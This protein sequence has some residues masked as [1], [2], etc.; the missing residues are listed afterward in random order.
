MRSAWFSGCILLHSVA[1]HHDLRINKRAAG[2]R[3][4]VIDRVRFEPSEP[5]ALGLIRPHFAVSLSAVTKQQQVGSI[6][7]FHLSTTGRT[8]RR[9]CK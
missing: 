9:C 3:G 8:G 5:V 6:E 2:N 1:H 7:R 4:F